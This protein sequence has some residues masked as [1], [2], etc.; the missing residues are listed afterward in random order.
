MSDAA[1]ALRRFDPLSKIEV[2]RLKGLSV[3]STSA[4][5]NRLQAAGS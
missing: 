2:V 4:I 1:L 5:M 3:Q